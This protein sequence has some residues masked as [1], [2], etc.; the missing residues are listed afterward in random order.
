MS[1]RTRKSK[2]K[3]KVVLQ[4]TFAG[5]KERTDHRGDTT[6]DVW[7]WSHQLL[8]WTRLT[9]TACGFDSLAAARPVAIE[10]NREVEQLVENTKRM[11]SA[12][13]D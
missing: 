12:L 7:K 1:Q 2:P 4:L 3:V 10:V 5:V 13:K 6:Y 8:K 11:P 9:L